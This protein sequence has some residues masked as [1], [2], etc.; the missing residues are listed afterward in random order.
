MKILIVRFSSIGD[1][2]LTTPVIK[3]LKQMDPSGQIHF[4]TKRIFASI[5]EN[6]ADLDRLH[7][8]DK[9]IVEVMNELRS[10]NFDLIVDLHNN[11]RTKALK[12]KLRRPSRTFR[13]LNI[14]KWLL[15]NFKINRL[16]NV[17]IVD[18]Y[19]DTVRDLI[20]TQPNKGVFIISDENKVDPM[21][22]LGVAEKSYI[23]V[24][25][26]AKFAT[27]QI[28][29]NKMK[30]ILDDIGLPIVLLGGPEDVSKANEIMNRVSGQVLNMCG[31]LNL[32]QSAS[33]VAQSKALLTSDTG[34]MHIAA[35]FDVPIVSVWGNTIP[36][37]G[38]FPYRPD[39]SESYTIHEVKGIGCRPCSKIGYSSCPKKH[40]DC[41]MKQDSAKIRKM[42]LKS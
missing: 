8:I 26:G 35:C 5:L 4:L 9:H 10:E 38:M 18:R 39:Q 1:I 28:P 23:A 19:L 12:S 2:V 21:E 41:M 25:I 15:V 24:A 34:L 14:A 11:L 32:Q 17:H 29:I 31:N 30:E 22:L 40:F 16:P 37:L 42:L 7:V 36:E 13:K 20:H 27:K 33:I 3:A 6:N